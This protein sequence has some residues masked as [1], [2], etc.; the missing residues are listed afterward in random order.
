MKR[1][2]F[3]EQCSTCQSGLTCLSIICRYYGRRINIT[4][5]PSQAMN[6]EESLQE[7]S[8]N[9]EK[10]GL[11]SIIGYLSLAKLGKITLPCILF[12]N[13]E[14]YVVLRRV[15]RKSYYIADPV[16]GLTEYNEADMKRHWIC[17]PHNN[18]EKGVAI[19]IKPSDEFYRQAEAQNQLII[20]NSIWRYIKKLLCGENR[21]L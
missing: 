8:N 20:E 2:D 10:L 16:K 15:K 5:T 18:E 17:S 19:F 13:N 3:I 1:F 21:I 7:V 9:A 4:A 6:V 12:W 11:N 14:Y